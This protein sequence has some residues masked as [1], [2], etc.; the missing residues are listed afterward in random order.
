MDNLDSSFIESPYKIW[1][2]FNGQDYDYARI[3]IFCDQNR[4]ALVFQKVGFDMRTNSINLSL[5]Y[6]GNCLVNQNRVT[7]WNYLSNFTHHVLLEESFFERISDEGYLLPYVKEVK[8]NNTTIDISS[9]LDSCKR[10]EKGKCTINSLSKYL[11][12]THP[13]LFTPPESLLRSCLP[14]DI[15][16]LGHLSE[17]Y[18]KDYVVMPHGTLGEKPSSY[19]TFK[20]VADCLVERSFSYWK[21]T[22]PPN[23]IK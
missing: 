14:T 18:H 2:S 5:Y 11:I 4:W 8:V 10:L 7:E 20:M 9:F 1:P 3:S 22:L 13:T 17:W 16:L 15:P 6:F 23:I 12:K 19:E 21:P